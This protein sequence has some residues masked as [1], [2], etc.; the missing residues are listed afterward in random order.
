MCET[1][2]TL[3][4]KLTEHM[5]AIQRQLAVLNQSP[6]QHPN[7]Q[8]TNSASRSCGKQKI[9]AV[10][11]PSVSPNPGFCFRCG[12]DGHI[13]PQCENYP[14]SELVSAKKKQFNE[15]KK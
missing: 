14:N 10:S 13:K 8:R 3:T 1:L 7:T 15:K 5:A 2:T 6:D 11:H 9:A 12:E 4:K